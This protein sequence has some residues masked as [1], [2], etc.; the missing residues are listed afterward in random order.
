MKDKPIENAPL[1]PLYSYEEGMDFNAVERVIMDRRSVR[2]FKKEPP[3]DSAIRRVL[4][5]GRF[6]PSA[7]NAQPW[8]FIVV[9]DPDL[10]EQM[11]R[12]T[13]KK[14]RF[15]M[16][17]L[18]YQKSA[19]RRLF[20]KPLIKLITRFMP[21]QLHPIPYNLMR[22]IAADKAPVY[23]GAPVMILLLI[24]K[25]G[26]GTPPLDLGI[27]GQNMVI[28]AHSLGLGTCWIGMITVL[29]K[30]RK[31]RKFFNV[32]YPYALT[33]CL[34]LGRPKR[35]F[36]GPVEREAQ[37]VEWFDKDGVRTED[38]GQKTS[39]LKFGERMRI[40]DYFSE[41]QV[42]SGQL[43]FD[44]DL[45]TGCGVCA[46][47]CPARG[48][49]MENRAGGK[50]KLPRLLNAA[51]GVSLCMT[52]GDCRAACPEGAIRLLRGYNTKYFYKKLSQTPELKPPQK[53]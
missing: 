17:F 38:D 52:C 8:K 42:G 13:Q 49:I 14:T 28:A 7:G 36:D 25:R 6:A 2:A 21:T 12:D 46:D 18:D 44:P 15:L 50:K 23:H 32:K 27:C 29:M 24:D 45:C 9:K 37:V 39:N 19:W 16:K 22:Q 43:E 10:L 26:V 53:Y 30:M 35:R 5:A 40:P 41:S 47:I 33:D 1:S 11:E 34:I 31:W 20:L 4:E 51:P 3:P 48:L